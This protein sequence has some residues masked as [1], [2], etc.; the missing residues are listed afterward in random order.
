MSYRERHIKNKIHGARP[1]K[2]IFKKLWFWILILIMVIALASGYFLFFYPYFQLKNIVISG[3][4]KVKTEDL[5]ALA[6]KDSNTS[7]LNFWNIKIGTESIFLINDNKINKDILEKFP[8]IGQLKINKTLPQT[9]ILGVTERKPLGVYCTQ[10]Q[11]CFLIDNNGIIFE[12]LAA[13]PVDATIVRQTVENS[14][15]FTGEGVVAQNIISAIAQIQKNLKD[16]FQINLK[17]A[18]IT[19]PVRL[20][21][22]TGENWQ[23]YFDLTPGSDIN[24]QL[25]ELTLLLNGGISKDT[26]KNLR[27]ID[28][29]PKDRAIICD[30][31][32][33]GGQ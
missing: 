22:D 14:N 2:S 10:V 21:I 28:L 33:C 8:A 16:N 13:T 11:Q 7:L 1:Q 27:Y 30:N 17:Q 15:I 6:W 29:R 20:N 31:S 26:Q 9:L 4:D 23:I 24:S 5:Q 25:T 3:N 18:L 19:S 12:P 32:T